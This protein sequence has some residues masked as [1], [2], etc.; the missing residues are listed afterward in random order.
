MRI[1]TADSNS[2]LGPIIADW[3]N[4]KIKTNIAPPYSLIGVIDDNFDIKGAI[5]FDNYYENGNVD[6]HLYVPGCFTRK[7]IKFVNNY[8]FNEL[9][10]IR[11]TAR[12]E[13][14][15]KKLLKILPRLG[16][17]YEATLKCYFGPHKE[18][19]AIIYVLRDKKCQAQK[20]QNQLTLHR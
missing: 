7:N 15:N 18:N 8:V 10:C 3:Y 12:V 2:K 17:K 5:F 6:I 20:Y 13:R 16:Y 19:D 1:I 11:L 4:K 14:K 9:K